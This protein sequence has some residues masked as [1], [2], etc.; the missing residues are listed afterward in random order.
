M[1]W[2]EFKHSDSLTFA[3]NYAT[4]YNHLD[5]PD[6]TSQFPFTFVPHQDD[7]LNEVKETRVSAN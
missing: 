5:K 7:S 6:G 4:L 3:R 1:A 2:T